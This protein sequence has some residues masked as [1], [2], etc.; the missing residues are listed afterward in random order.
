MQP[1]WIN[2]ACKRNYSVNSSLTLSRDS[3][4]LLSVAL[5]GLAGAKGVTNLQGYIGAANF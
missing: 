4:F 2:Q 5:L 3:Q 1:F